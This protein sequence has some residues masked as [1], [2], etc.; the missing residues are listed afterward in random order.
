MQAGPAH[1]IRVLLAPDFKIRMHPVSLPAFA[2][3][4]GIDQN[5]E[6]EGRDERENLCT[7]ESQNNCTA[8]WLP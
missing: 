5:A 7:A 2:P 1:G 8:L 6:H 4:H 3:S